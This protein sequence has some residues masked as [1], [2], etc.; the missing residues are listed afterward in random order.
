[1]LVIVGRILALLP[2]SMFFP[3]PMLRPALAFV[4]TLTCLPAIFLTAGTTTVPVPVGL[5]N[6][7]VLSDR[8]D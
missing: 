8:W 2:P 7:D 3:P 6:G 1:M 5:L 4:L